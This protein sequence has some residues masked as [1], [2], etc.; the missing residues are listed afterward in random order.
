MPNDFTFTRRFIPITGVLAGVAILVAT[1]L[2]HPAWPVTL[3]LTGG[4]LL[5]L[6]ATGGL[7][8]AC[9]GLHRQRAE[10]AEQTAALHA[11]VANLKIQYQEEAAESA[12]TCEARNAAETGRQ[13]LE[14]SL[15]SAAHQASAACTLTLETGENVQQATRGV[16]AMGDAIDA[17][18]QSSSQIS[19]ILATI[20]KIAFQTNILALNAAVEAARAG[21]AGAG[22][23]VVA[24]EVQRLAQESTTAAK[25][26]AEHVDAAV[27]WIL[28]CE[29]LKA[30]AVS[31]LQ[32]VDEKVKQLHLTAEALSQS[33][34]AA[35]TSAGPTKVPH[36]H[37]TL[38][39]ESTPAARPA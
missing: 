28:Q 15:R 20:N 27:S 16:Q 21:E 19:A 24:S 37:A 5:T 23:T 31:A 35:G 12:R 22:F 6:A 36:A 13:Q 10:A 32:G 18:N 4:S 39:A 3:V 29:M 34:S 7:A 2:A 9:E 33:M 14:S 11:E 26:T 30:E 25:Q 8:A 1:W 17:L 38:V